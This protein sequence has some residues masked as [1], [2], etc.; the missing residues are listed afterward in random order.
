MCPKQG[1]VAPGSGHAQSFDDTNSYIAHVDAFFDTYLMGERVLFIPWVVFPLLDALKLL[2]LQMFAIKGSHHR[3]E[4]HRHTH[5]SHQ[6]K[7]YHIH[8]PSL[9]LPNLSTVS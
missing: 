5:H 1:L 6:H 9:Q 8:L 2:C 4:A 3:H 7:R